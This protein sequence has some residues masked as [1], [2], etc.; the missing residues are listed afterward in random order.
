MSAFTPVAVG[1][2]VTILPITLG[3]HRDH[4]GR[5]PS[6]ETVVKVGRTYAHTDK[7]NRFHLDSGNVDAGRGYS[8]TYRAYTAEQLAHRDAVEAAAQRITERGLRVSTTSGSRLSDDM[9]L[10]LAVFLD[11]R[12]DLTA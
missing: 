9:T 2:T 4:T 1:D 7:G 12:P 10:A 6:V 5:R 8:P 3:A 11:K